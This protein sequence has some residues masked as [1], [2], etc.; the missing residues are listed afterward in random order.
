MRHRVKSKTFGRDTQHRQALI[1][2]LVR[3]LVLHGRIT[4]TLAKAKEV[5]RW[6]DKLVYRAQSDE[7]ATRRQ[8]HKFF[9]KRDVVNTLVERVAPAFKGR[10]SGYS[11]ISIV[12]K[13]RGDNTKLVRI[14]LLEE[15]D[16]VGTLKSGKSH[17]KRKPKRAKRKTKVRK[18]KKTQVKKTNVKKTEVKK[19]EVKKTKVKKTS[20]SKK[21]TAKK[22]TRT[23]KSKSKTATYQGKKK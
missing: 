2:N 20:T 23:K 21:S 5:K 16:R 11:R 8:L 1:K 4:T 18:T 13:R 17:P 15:I 3:E 9:G 7:I 10:T 14:S 22:V 6:T 19:A 12:G